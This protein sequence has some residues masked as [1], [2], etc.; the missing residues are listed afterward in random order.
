MPSGPGFF[1]HF[2]EN[3]QRDPMRIF[4]W[5]AV[6][7][8]IFLTLIFF[9]LPMIRMLQI[10]FYQHVAGG[11]MVPDFST[12]NYAA[13]L[14]DPYYLERL[15][16]TLIYGIIVTIFCFLLGFPLAYTLVRVRTRATPL[17][18][19]IVLYPLLTN[20]LVLVFA[21]LVIFGYQGPLN[22]LLV[23]LIPSAEPLRIIG[24]PAAVIIAMVHA[25]LPFM[26][27]PLM[28]AISNIPPSLE[29]AATSLG[30]SRMAIMRR[31]VIPLAMPGI[32]AG[33]LIAFTTVL[34]GFLFPLYLGSNA[35]NILPL[36]IYEK[37][38]EAANWPFGATMTFMVLL[39]TLIL[40][41]VGT[42]GVNLAG[43][44]FR[45]DA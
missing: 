6:V 42:S 39:M 1:K 20:A 29:D 32:L 24:T 30:A 17:L 36:L 33:S 38:G 11:L 41:G 16:Q 31:I 35:T 44:M 40:I 34:S 21:W 26:I 23:I 10:S 14:G 5:L 27:L 8:A 4:P 25:G 7:P 28:A 37:I 19:G 13:F 12:E 3:L 43:R 45:S 9:F 18:L 22:K 15:G 2:T